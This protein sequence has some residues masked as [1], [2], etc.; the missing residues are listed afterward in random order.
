MISFPYLIFKRPNNAKEDSVVQ[1]LQQIN[2]SFERGVNDE[3]KQDIDN[4]RYTI[5][6]ERTTKGLVG[7]EEPVRGVKA[8]AVSQ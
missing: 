4:S 8:T 2:A 1:Q 5:D 7:P 6:I 3:T